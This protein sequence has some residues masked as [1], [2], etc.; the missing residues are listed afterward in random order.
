MNPLTGL[1]ERYR[2]DETLG[3]RALARAFRATDMETGDTLVLKSVRYPVWFSTYERIFHQRRAL[4]SLQA[5]ADARHP[6]CASVYAVGEA[7]FSL[8]VAREWVNGMPLSAILRQEGKL[9]TSEVARIARQCSGALDALAD[10]DL[11][12]GAL[13]ADNLIVCED[14]SV[15]LTDACFS[16]ET[17]RFDLA[18]AHCDFRDRTVHGSDISALADILLAAIDGLHGA[19]QHNL[20]ANRMTA[21]LKRAQKNARAYASAASLADALSSMSTLAIARQVWR[22]ATATGL[23]AAFGT[24]CVFALSE[25]KPATHRQV[26]A[27]PASSIVATVGSTQVRPESTSLPASGSS[28]SSSSSSTLPTLDSLTPDEKSWLGLVVRRQGIAALDRPTVAD[29]FHLDATQRAQIQNL[30]HDQRAHLAAMVE[31]AADNGVS[32]D[33]PIRT[34]SVRDTTT[35]SVLEALSPAQRDLWRMFL[36]TAGHEPAEGEPVL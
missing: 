34:Q 19:G 17:S 12:H 35:E 36:P 33:A 2:V 21:A 6:S 16:E 31:Q 7:A 27:R 23:M 26:P 3:R 10:C 29:V 5:A 24:V 18:G 13:T 20:A 4:K 8:F 9:P 28:A 22:P 1:P 25:E 11:R 30:L 32:T 14:G 15:R